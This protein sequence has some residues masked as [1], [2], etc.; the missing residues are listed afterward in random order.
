MTKQSVFWYKQP[1]SSVSVG[2]PLKHVLLWSN[3][4]TITIHSSGNSGKNP[5]TQQQSSVHFFTVFKNGLEI[6]LWPKLEFPQG[7]P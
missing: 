5:H 4:R 3:P 2:E 7:I 1:V 6:Q